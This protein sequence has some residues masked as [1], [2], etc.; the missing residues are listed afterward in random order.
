MSKVGK[1][2]NFKLTNDLKDGFCLLA[3]ALFELNTLRKES[4]KPDMNPQFHHLCKPLTKAKAK[5]D[6][7]TVDREYCSLLFG[8][9]L[10][11]QVK[12]LQDERKATLGVTKSKVFKGQNK[13]TPYSKRPNQSAKQSFHA[14][15]AAAGWDRSAGTSNPFL[16]KQSF[17]RKQQFRKNNRQ[18]QSFNKTSGPK[19]SK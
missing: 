10:G 3:N 5:K 15:A 9:D 1:D 11:K 17:N 16:G 2:K 12:D 18:G 14:A 6:K 13:F 4:M 7:I 19:D 8:T